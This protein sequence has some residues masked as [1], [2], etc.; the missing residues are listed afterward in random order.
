MCVGSGVP[1][2]PTNVPC[3]IPW[4]EHGAWAVF[5]TVSVYPIWPAPALPGIRVKTAARSLPA[6]GFA[7][8]TDPVVVTVWVVVRVVV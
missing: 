5:F 7:E 3:G 1:L 2:T 8:A 6:H 4:R